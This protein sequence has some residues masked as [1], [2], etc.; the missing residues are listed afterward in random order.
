MSNTPKEILYDADDIVRF[1]SKVKIGAEDECWP[2]T[3]GATPQGYG[4]FWAKGQNV[5][6]NRFAL[7]ITEGP[8][9]DPT[10]LSLHECDNPPCC[11]PKHLRWGTTQDNTDDSLE[12]SGPRHGE[13]SSNAFLTEAIVIRLYAHR[14]EGWKIREAAKME[15]IPYTAAEN[16]LTG[17]S[18]SHLLGVNG[19][20][21]LEQ[22][23]QKRPMKTKQP[24]HTKYMTDEIIDRIYAMR[25]SGMKVRDIAKEL[26]FAVG[27][28]SP[29]FCGHSGTHR[30][31]VEGNPT[32]EQLK[33]V[34]AVSSSV[35]LTADDRA[36]IVSLLS[37]GYTGASIAKKFSVT[38]A[39]VSRIKSEHF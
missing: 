38:P 5:R 24:T 16:V 39:T 19:N 34:R 10:H 3:E 11:N 27:T 14:M 28:V 22:L 8:S 30:L 13:N 31:G 21:T 17:R 9:T 36:E 15:G 4:V 6:A 20:P 33:G 23:R 1:W 25:M 2:W 7:T 29:I 32:L 18:W 37:K 35:K 26:G 12:R